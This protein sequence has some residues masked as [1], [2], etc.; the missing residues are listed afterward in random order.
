MAL[1]EYPG[2]VWTPGPGFDPGRA[3]QPIKYLVIHGTASPNQDIDWWAS[4]AATRGGT[5]YMVG[6]SAHIISG[7][8]TQIIQFVHEADTAYGNGFPSISHPPLGCVPF[9]PGIDPNQQ[10]ISIEHVKYNTDN[11]DNLTT[12]E[13]TA[14]IN[15]C[16]Y[17]CEKYHIPKRWA[18]STGGFLMHAQIDPENRYFCPGPV[19]WG[20]LFTGIQ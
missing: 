16:K 7:I 18:D 15:L 10:T 3:G 12:S 20:Q 9:F 5:H 19:N 1:G 11:S 13:M 6:R 2:S 4:Q 14:T 8:T 17:L